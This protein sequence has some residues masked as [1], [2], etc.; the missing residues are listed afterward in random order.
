MLSRLLTQ[1]GEKRGWPVWNMVVRIGR[2]LSLAIGLISL[3]SGEVT[4]RNKGL[5]LLRQENAPAT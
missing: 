1:L 4:F 3:S 5:N 2:R